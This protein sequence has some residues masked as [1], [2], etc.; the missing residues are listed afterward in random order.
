MTE[1]QKIEHKKTTGASQENQVVH[2][3]DGI[4][5]YD[6]H[7]P[8]WWLLTLY[9]AIVFAVGYWGYYHTFAAG[10]LPTQAYR[11]ELAEMAERLGKSVPLTEAAL[12]DMSKD[13][14]ALAEGQQLFVATCAACHGAN[15]GGTVGPNLTDTAWLHGGNA[16]AILKSVQE[17]Y[18]QKGMPAWGAQLGS[19]KT[20]L[21]TAYVLS[22]RNTN[23][24]GGKPP[25]GETAAPK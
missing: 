23:V 12:V 4:E 3:V 6:N 7:L 11:R 9:G 16:E 19:R 8:N 24:P 21:V 20:P 1:H 18:P 17:G 25:Q 15:G 14:Q 10:E 22:L 2:V 5:E 13:P